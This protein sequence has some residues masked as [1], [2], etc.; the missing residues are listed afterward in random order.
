MS[1]AGSFRQLPKITSSRPILWHGLTRTRND[2]YDTVKVSKTTLTSKNLEALGAA[3]LAE[4]LAKLP[5][6][7]TLIR[8]A[9]IDF[10]LGVA[11][12]SRYRHA[13][14]HLLKRQSLAGQIGDFGGF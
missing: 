12:T 10:L 2:G 7:A 8:R 1:C 11:R 9:L 5:L 3:R 13:A 14:R 4:L 6:P